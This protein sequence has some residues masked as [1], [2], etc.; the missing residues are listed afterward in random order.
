MCH[1]YNKFYPN[2]T[3]ADLPASPKKP[4]PPSGSW[5]SLLCKVTT[6]TILQERDELA[7][8]WASPHTPS[9]SDPIQYWVGVL[10]GQPESHLA[11]M[12]IDYLSIPP[13]LVDVECA[14]SHGALTVTHCQHTLSNNSTCNSIVVSGWLKDTSLVPK[15]DLIEFFGGKGF[16][17]EVCNQAPA[18]GEVLESQDSTE[19]ISLNSDSDS[20]T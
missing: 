8:F 9:G 20:D 18:C 2:V 1:I 19:K 10:V 13:T 5:P 6:K 16:R 14:F 17:G 11:Q 12:A 15:D 3:T 4:P 7:D